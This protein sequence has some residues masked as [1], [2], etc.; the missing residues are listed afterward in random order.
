MTARQAKIVALNHL[1]QLSNNCAKAQVSSKMEDAYFDLAAQLC[2]ISTN[3][4]KSE[5]RAKAK[6]AGTLPKSSIR[7]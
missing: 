3:L 5:D 1:Q 6:K 2:R 7:R 4:Q